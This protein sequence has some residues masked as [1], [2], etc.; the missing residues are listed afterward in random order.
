MTKPLTNLKRETE[1]ANAAL[2]KH[3]SDWTKKVNRQH[4][5]LEALLT[6]LEEA[7]RAYRAKRPELEQRAAVFN[8]AAKLAEDGMDPIIA[9]M[10]APDILRDE[11]LR[12]QEEDESF[13]S[14]FDK[15]R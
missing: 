13:N 5:K 10:T 2:A 15:I 11:A 7:G 6:E 12:Q 4:A 9:K 3:D 14:I 8:K 1:R